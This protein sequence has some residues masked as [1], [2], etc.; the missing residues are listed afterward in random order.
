MNVIKFIEYSR[1]CDRVDCTVR[2]KFKFSIE[3]FDAITG[4]CILEN[5]EVFTD[6]YFCCKTV[7]TI[8]FNK[9]CNRGII[10]FIYQKIRNKNMGMKE[11]RNVYIT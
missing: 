2:K 8:D 9:V 4:E 5:Q 7:N 1:K 10:N 11:P 6:K 3:L